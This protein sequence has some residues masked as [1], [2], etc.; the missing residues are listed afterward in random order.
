M[1]ESRIDRY[2]LVRMV[3]HFIPQ[4]G[5]DF[6]MLMKSSLYFLHASV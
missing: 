2:N 6:N 3:V 5:L 4:E 1:D